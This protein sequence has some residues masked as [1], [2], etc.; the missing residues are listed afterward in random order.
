MWRKSVV[1]WLDPK[2]PISRNEYG[3]RQ[4]IALVLA[5]AL[6]GPID[7]VMLQSRSTVS[8]VLVLVGA[9]AVL[10]L[11]SLL[12][13][14]RLLDVGW[15]RYWTLMMLG[16]V[17]MYALLAVGRLSPGLLHAAFIPVGLLFALGGALIAALFVKPGRVAL[18][19]NHHPSGLSNR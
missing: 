7:S 9:T 14:K 3:I 8:I 2:S 4:F 17:L 11:I 13:A 16:P 10:S 15:S 6:L 12:T 1:N 19:L 18:P 5:G